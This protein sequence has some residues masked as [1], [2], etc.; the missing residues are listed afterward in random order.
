MLT[1][2]QKWNFEGLGPKRLFS[3]TYAPIWSPVCADL[4]QIDKLPVIRYNSH[5]QVKTR[6]DMPWVG[7]G[8]AVSNFPKEFLHEGDIKIAF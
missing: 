2:A 5:N 4:C 6:R 8:P 3:T 1:V 7:Y